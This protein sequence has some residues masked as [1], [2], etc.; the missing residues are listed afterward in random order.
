MKTFLIVILS[1]ILALSGGLL[2]YGI[3]LGDPIN[4]GSMD[5][6]EL[7][8]PENPDAFAHGIAEQIVTRVAFDPNVE[9]AKTFTDNPGKDPARFAAEVDGWFDIFGK[10]DPSTSI[11]TR[12]K[13]DGAGLVANLIVPMTYN[14]NRCTQFCMT[15]HFEIR[16][17]RSVTYS[18]NRRVHKQVEP[19][20]ADCVYLSRVWPGYSEGS[21][22]SF[23]V[24]YNTQQLEF[25]SIGVIDDYHEDTGAY[26]VKIGAP[27][28]RTTRDRDLVREQPYK[29]YDLLTFPIWLGD[30]DVDPS[31][32]DGNSVVLTTPTETVPYYTL[33]FSE[34]LSKAQTKE[35]KND[36]LNEALGGQ[37]SGITIKKADFVVEFWDSG[38]F[39]RLTANFVVD[40]T[41]NNKKGEAEIAMDYK[42]YYD[43]K[44]CDI[45]SLIESVGWQKK[46]FNKKNK[47]EFEF[48]K[49]NQ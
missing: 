28:T 17:G 31:V 39:R 5:L 6:G 37:M 16:A 34:D 14:E 41:I 18:D 33:T 7:L 8:P 22:A 30:K 27:T 26:E 12:Y 19:F 9:Y 20:A 23:R 42:F 1:I 24:Y 49:N 2:V 10:N 29:T 44:S 13:N 43:N 48:R 3:T 47:E 15:S 46:Y 36:R 38:V 4:F 40:A 32:I 45:Y 21:S 25:A 35:N 11:L